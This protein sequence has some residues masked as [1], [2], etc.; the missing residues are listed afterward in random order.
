MK[1]D[2]PACAFSGA[3]FAPFSMKLEKHGY[4][5]DI[6]CFRMDIN[7]RV[8]QLGEFGYS[9]MLIYLK[10]DDQNNIVE[11]FTTEGMMRDDGK[12]VMKQL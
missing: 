9:P 10:K 6:K 11:V 5:D 4:G 8:P 1:K 2:C 7:N 12:A 3:V